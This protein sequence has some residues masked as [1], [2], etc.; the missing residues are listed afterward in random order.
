M[1]DLSTLTE[2]ASAMFL[3]RGVDHCRADVEAR[4]MEFWD[5]HPRG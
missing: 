2:I 1:G 4:R 5:S 3:A